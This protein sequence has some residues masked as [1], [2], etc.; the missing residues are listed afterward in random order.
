ML[1]VKNLQ[2]VRGDHCLFSDLSFT[3]NAGELLHL[4]GVNGAGKTTLLRALAGLLLPVEG[5]IY[6]SG[7]PI[8]KHRDEYYEHVTFLGHLNGI[9]GDLTT[10]E[11]IALHAELAGQTVDD[12][13]V[14]LALKALGLIKRAELPVKVLSQGQQKRVALARLLVIPRTLWILDEPFVALDVG[15]VDWLQKIIGEHLR[16][17]AMVVLTTHQEVEID[18]G[19]KRELTLGQAAQIGQTVVQ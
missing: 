10:Y 2:C 3:L 5:E 15:A 18:A 7:K 12:G 19:T 16:K 8:R 14:D 1:E 11:N 17:N 6:W 9:K 4:R 13:V